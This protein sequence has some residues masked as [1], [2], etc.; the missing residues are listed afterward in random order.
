MRMQDTAQQYVE[1]LR[2]LLG[3]D[4]SIIDARQVRIAGSG[5]MKARRGSVARYGCI[6]RHTLDTGRVTVVE[7]PT[8]N[9]ICAD[10][11]I[12]GQCDN[13][14]EMWSPIML[15]GEAIGVIGCVCYTPEQKEIFLRRRET[16][17][18][19]FTQFAGL[20]ES[21]AHD[22]VDVD[23]HQN[24]C[25][26]LERVL[27][28]AQIGSLILD[29]EG[30][31][32]DV[33]QLGKQLLGLEESGADFSSLTI[34]SAGPDAPKE[35]RIHSPGCTRRVVA[36]IYRLS[37]DPYDR[38]MLF[39][40]AELRSDIS[41]GLLG[42]T[43]PGDLDRIVGQSGAIRTLKRNIRMVAASCSN[44]LITGESGTGKELAARA[45]HSGSD[46]K[47]GPFVAVNCA[48]LP[49]NLLESELFGYV[50]GAFTG[51]SA[52]GRAG[53]LESAQNG[54][55]FLDEVGEMPPSLQVK[56]LR[57]L[58]QREITRLGSNVPTPINARFV[59]AS[60]RDLAEMAAEGTFRK[61]LYYRINVV[62]LAIPPLRE[63][64]E[65]IRLLAGGFIRK[66][67]I[68]MNKPCRRVTE[69]FWQALERYSWPGNVRELQ[70]AVEFA[71]NMMPAS[72]V[73]CAD[74]LRGK[75]A[76][77]APEL[78]AS[79]PG[80]AAPPGEDWNLRH[81][82]AEIIRRC[83][84]RYGDKPTAA[85]ELGISLATLYR[86]MKEYHL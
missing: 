34:Q 15:D 58:E 20:L 9:P 36:D 85:R 59:F 73:L 3:I 19:F 48:A 13:L 64:P 10:C 70:N 68:A 50:K 26:V 8:V 46:R 74:L 14:C 83:L 65:D 86:K 75:I 43:P 53:L 17:E 7:N 77:P 22:L 32:F 23:R 44:V 37:M 67:S 33:N 31:V 49:E 62:P 12:R 82:E 29:A 35:Y 6:V 52:S 66:F 76:P 16:F 84:A 5:R 2:D 80:E 63:R 21:R 42:L 55:F 4:V 39:S 28:R 72:G 57:V 54:T 71:V 69:D 30:R 27:E 78:P 11:G 79:L 51:A 81:A 60:N 40:D 45:I 18:Q 38:L 47:N 56:L 41:D 25:A 61:D 1:I 24:V